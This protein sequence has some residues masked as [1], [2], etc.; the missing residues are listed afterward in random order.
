[1]SKMKD[2]WLKRARACMK[3][4]DELGLTQEDV[5]GAGRSFLLNWQS[6]ETT[7]VAFTDGSY[8]Y[9]GVEA[10]I[11]C[12]QDLTIGKWIMDFDIACLLINKE[13][14]QF[15][16]PDT[17]SHLTD[18]GKICQA[19]HKLN[20]KLQENGE[21]EF[22][23]AGHKLAYPAESIVYYLHQNGKVYLQWSA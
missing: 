14:E 4:I 2:A 10:A 19:F 16:D 1:M 9:S 12:Q 8:R 5:F 13:L 15:F 3:E 20:P 18:F 6:E 7:H 11:A 23:Y 21:V 22:S 17:E